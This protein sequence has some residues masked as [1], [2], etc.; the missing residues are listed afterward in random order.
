MAARNQLIQ[1]KRRTKI[2]H[3]NVLARWGFCYSLTERS[4]P[5]PIPYPADSNLEMTWATFGGKHADGL[6]AA[7]K[8]WLRYHSLDT[9]DTTLAKYLRLHLHRGIGYLAGTPGLDSIEALVELVTKPRQTILPPTIVRPALRP[10]IS[11]AQTLAPQ[12]ALSARP[13]PQITLAPRLS[14]QISPAPP[15]DAVSFLRLPP[16]NS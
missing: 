2:E 11:I 5:S 6:L 14:P 15:V 16:A 8:M 9:D 3:Y 4:E 7:L 10:Q 1:L 13:N 12:I